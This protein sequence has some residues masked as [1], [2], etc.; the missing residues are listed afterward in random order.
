MAN[1][2]TP[3]LFVEGRSQTLLWRCMPKNNNEIPCQGGRV[4]SLAESCWLKK[5]KAGGPLRA[6][7]S[8]SLWPPPEEEFPP[9]CSKPQKKKTRQRQSLAT[10]RRG[11]GRHPHELR[12][13]ADL[14]DGECG[15]RGTGHPVGPR[16]AEGPPPR[17]DLH[18]RRA[19]ERLGRDGDGLHRDVDAGGPDHLDLQLRAGP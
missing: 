14:R 13:A 10:V 5:K 18:A 17:A 6:E 19:G 9:P 1:R 8:S 12:E 7:V 2:S 16:G 3:G 11:G 4:C 15:W